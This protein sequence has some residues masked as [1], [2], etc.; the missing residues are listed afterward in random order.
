MTRISHATTAPTRVRVAIVDDH[1]L[2][3]DGLTA[4]LTKPRTGVEVTSAV[5]TWNA[6]LSS[7]DFPPDV[8]V[9][10]L[11]LE[12]D[13]PIGGKIRTLSAAGSKTIVV[14]RHADIG[15]I[16]GAI[17]A[18]AAGFLPKTESAAEL[19]ESIHAASINRQRYSPA[20][21]VA[22][23]NATMLRDPRLGRQEQRALTLYAG[24]RSIREVADEMDTTQETIKSYIKRA[25][26]KHLAVGVD[27][28]TKQ[29]LRRHA[30]RQGWI[31]PEQ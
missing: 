30:I 8:A 22:L 12:D 6:L 27:L 24:G 13:V 5:T 14:S 17:A 1:Q 26:R 3:L 16:R 28:G 23:A 9:I 2:L 19:I 20:V 31:A 7:P 29:L 15:S 11:G 4:R 10:D 25:R 21:Q 18:G